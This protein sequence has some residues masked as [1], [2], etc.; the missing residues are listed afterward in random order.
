MTKKEKNRISREIKAILDE[1]KEDKQEFGYINDGQGVRYEMGEL[2]VRIENY[3]GLLDYYSWFYENFPDDIGFP[4]LQIC[5]IIGGIKEKRKE[6]INKHLV[7]LE[8]INTYVLPKLLKQ[9]Y[10]KTERWEGMNISTEDYANYVVE[11]YEKYIDEEVKS[12]LQSITS[13]EKYL[14]NKLELVNNYVKLSS[15]G[16]GVK[17]SKVITDNDDL[18][19]KWEAELNEK[20]S[21]QS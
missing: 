4:E 12:Y 18:L 11:D 13:D 16:R 5:W 9:D 19:I 21:W 3:K 2:Y 1:F 20:T 6:I 17:R 10:P 7:Q 15:L 14:K 8:D